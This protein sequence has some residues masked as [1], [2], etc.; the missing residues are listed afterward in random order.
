MLASLHRQRDESL[1]YRVARKCAH[2][3]DSELAM[4]WQS[5]LVEPSKRRR[6]L[7]L[8]F[9]LTWR[10]HALLSYISA[11]GAHRDRLEPIEGLDDISRHISHTLERAA[12]HLAGEIPARLEG[13]CP[14]ITPDSS[15]EQLMLTQQLTL[16]SQLADELL[17]LA[18]DGQLLTRQGNV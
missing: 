1:D 17:M 12:G 3:A 7:D 6:F 14:A 15:E 16:I 5:M 10:N 8:C 2:L 11:L 13:P 18:N 4:A 9:T